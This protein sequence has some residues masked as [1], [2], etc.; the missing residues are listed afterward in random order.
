MSRLVIL[1]GS[2]GSLS[3]ILECLPALEVPLNCCLLIVIHRRTTDHA[4]ED[5]LR[6][7]TAN[8]VK[9]VEEKDAILAGQIYLAP[10]DYHLLIE[11][12]LTFSLDYSEPVNYSRPSIDVVFESAATV[13]GE[14]TAG[15]LL[16]GA[17]ND[18]ALGLLRI[19]E[20]GGMIFVQHPAT[21]EVD[22]MPQSALQVITPDR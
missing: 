21:A 4:L 14:K 3:V 20:A 8:P 5:L 12:D 17:N 18:G 11:Q 13:L 16:S 19:K 15:I 10:G 2:A 9:E 22:F 6:H 1:A 7:K